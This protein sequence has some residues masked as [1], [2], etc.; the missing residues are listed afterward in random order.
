MGR[1]RF[2]LLSIYTSLLRFDLLWD[3]RTCLVASIWINIPLSILYMVFV[4]L[5]SVSCSVKF[6]THEELVHNFLRTK[7][8]GK[9][10]EMKKNQIFSR[11]P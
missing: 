8:K 3:E 7:N 2:Q 11:R 1:F 5:G 9:I 10:L 4:K 6:P